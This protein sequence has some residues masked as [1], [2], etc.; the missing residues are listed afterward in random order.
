MDQNNHTITLYTT[1][2]EPVLE[3]LR[4]DGVCYSRE[5]YLR[6][7]YD[8]DGPLFLTVYGWF[9]EK[10]EEL[11]P[12]PPEA[13]Y[14]YW[15]YEHPYD[16][17]SGGDGKLL[18][19]EVPSS[20]VLLFDTVEWQKILSLQYLGESAQE[21]RMKQELSARGIQPN[22]VMLT[23]FYPELK[24][25]ILSSWNRLLRNNNKLRQGMR[26]GVQSMQ[27]A[28]WCI[29]REWICGAI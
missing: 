17:A 23:G 21:K 1:Q 5:A 15:V 2:T 9:V 3:C 7:K 19:L 8:Q 28:L 4:S 22:D 26:C 29:R 14:P 25:Q 27:G 12:P 20:E 13:E 24:E 10:A 11:L 6:S 16:I 18:K